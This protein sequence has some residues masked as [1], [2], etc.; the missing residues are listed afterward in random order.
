MAL[1]FYSI[2]HDILGDP[3]WDVYKRGLADARQRFD[4]EVHHLAPAKFDVSL[5]IDLIE[6]AIA[7]SPDGIIATIPDAEA[8]DHCLRAATI[9]GI[10]LIAVNARDTRAE[11]ERIPYL[12][13]VGGDDHL[14]GKV[15]GKRVLDEGRPV[16]AL[17]IDHYEVPHV[18]HRAR[19]AGFVEVMASSGVPTSQLA[20][21][22][23]R[24]DKAESLVTEFLDASPEIDAVCS[25]GPPG[26][27]AAIAALDRLDRT[28]NTNH[29]T[30]D[31]A[32]AQIEAVKSGLAL[33]TID[34]QQYLQAFLGIELLWLYL[35]FGFV[36]VGDI[37]TGPAVV[38]RTNVGSVESGV[39]A[40]YR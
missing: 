5:Q 25:L 12:C 15:A 24:A 16:A 32:P 31:L 2:T 28:S 36:P 17:A 20:I 13:Y 27:T 29:I 3:F 7:T 23:S 40:G 19:I 10:P 39:L 35:T 37:L 9:N 33:A 4:V 30:F 14:G 1:T 22:G 26:A 8:L 11:S 18:G 38:D 34:Y 6:Q 21:P